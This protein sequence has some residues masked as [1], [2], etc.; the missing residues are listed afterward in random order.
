MSEEWFE[1]LIAAI[2]ASGRPKR[3]ISLGAGLG[4]GYVHAMMADGRQ[5]TVG[6]FLSLCEE[7]GVSPLEILSGTGL[8]PETD[9]LLSLF[10][11]LNQDQRSA[12]LNLLQQ[13]LGR[14]PV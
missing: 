4:H 7:L 3:D 2:E 8:G 14:Q 6:N 5:P 11:S 9:R 10:G 12:V 1:R 13:M